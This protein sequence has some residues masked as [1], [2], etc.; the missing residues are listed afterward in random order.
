MQK[1]FILP[2]ERTLRNWLS[3][4]TTKVG[5]DE[6]MLSLLETIVPKW[7]EWDRVISVVL[8]EISLKENITYCAASDI[9]YGYSECGC[10]GEEKHVDLEIANQALVILLKG[11]TRRYKQVVGYFLSTNAMKAHCLRKVLLNCIGRLHKCGFIV[12]LVVCDQGTSNVSMRKLLNVT[13]NEPF[14]TVNGQKIFFFYDTPHLLKSIRNNLKS[15]VFL[16]GGVHIRWKYIEK[17][18]RDDMTCRIRLAPKVTSKH[19]DLPPFA[20]MRVCYA[21]QV[22]SH[23]VSSAMNTY[24]AKQKLPSEA[25]YTAEF[26][27]NID[28]LFDTFNSVIMATPKK[29]RKPLSATSCHWAHL[30]KMKNFFLN[31]EIVTYKRKHTQKGTLQLFIAPLIFFS[32]IKLINFDCLFL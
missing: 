16:F 6:T 26:I 15:H 19:I 27:E 14:L 17:L 28:K 18:C 7:P 12:K 8:D 13:A 25:A 20:P 11:V 9:V 22:L 10:E 31:M 24:V 29:F 23:S 30:E 3:K 2:C 4:I 21:A 1:N 32:T 5:L